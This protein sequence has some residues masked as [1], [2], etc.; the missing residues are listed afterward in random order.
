MEWGKRKIIRL[1]R[2][3]KRKTP[4]LRFAANRKRRFA[5]EAGGLLSFFEKRIPLFLSYSKLRKRGILSKVRTSLMRLRAKETLLFLYEQ[6]NER[7]NFRIVVRLIPFNSHNL[8]TV[9]PYLEAIAPK[10]S[11]DFTRW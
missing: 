7:P 9:V 11:P 2:P 3:E 1:R 6:R 4:P 5:W 8:F 10:V